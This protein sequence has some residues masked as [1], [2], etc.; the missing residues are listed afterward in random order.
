MTSPL[1]TG[2]VSGLHRKLPAALA[3]SRHSYRRTRLA[4]VAAPVILALDAMAV[5]AV[6]LA[7]PTRTWTLSLAAAVSVGRI[8]LTARMLP[9]LAVR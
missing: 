7:A 5:T 4:A 6:V 2:Y 1:I 9:R 8:T 3:D